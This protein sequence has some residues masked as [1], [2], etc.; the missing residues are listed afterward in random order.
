MEFDEKN[1]YY[2]KDCNKIYNRCYE[3]ENI[4]MCPRCFSEDIKILNE[5]NAKAFIRSKRLKRIKEAMILGNDE[6]NP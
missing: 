5:A 3:L 2:C 4:Y 6:K 1:V